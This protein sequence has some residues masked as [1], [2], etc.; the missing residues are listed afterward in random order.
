M[1]AEEQRNP[2]KMLLLSVQRLWFSE[3]YQVWLSGSATLRDGPEGL[4]VGATLWREA[5]FH[6]TSCCWVL[7]LHP[8]GEPRVVAV[9]SSSVSLKFILTWEHLRSSA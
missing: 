4:A 5:P 3:S 7:V 6:L 9:I 2:L 1:L 8:L